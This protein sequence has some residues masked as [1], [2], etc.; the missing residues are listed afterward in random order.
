MLPFLNHN[1][2]EKSTKSKSTK[3]KSK[4]KSTKSTKTK[5][6]STKIYYFDIYRG[7]RTETLA[8]NKSCCLTLMFQSSSP[9]NIKFS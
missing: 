8:I 2:S 7:E 9:G 6:K 1:E 3:T 4:S 5:S